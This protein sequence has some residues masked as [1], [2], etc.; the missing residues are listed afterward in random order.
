MTAVIFDMDGTLLDT[1]RIYQK[2]W[3]IAAK[4]QGYSITE[5]Q[6]LLFRSL[7][8]SFAIKLMEEL[9]GDKEA[10][11]KIRNN[12]KRLMEPIMDESDIP[13]KPTVEEALQKLKKNGFITAI[14]TATEVKRAEEYLGRAGI[15]E[16]FDEILSTKQV[17]LGKPAPDV[18][19]YACEKLGVK[20][21][22]TFAIEDSPNGIRSAAAAGCRTIMIPDLT[23]PDDEMRSLIEYSKP[24]LMEAVEYMMRKDY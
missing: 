11:D 6:M 16:Y 20:P 5:E 9:T 24:T 1:E 2:Y 7:G 14:A 21:E 12:R 18:Y 3:N 15:R 22:D 10:Y 17:S 23:E 4:E 8:R 13:L 19:L